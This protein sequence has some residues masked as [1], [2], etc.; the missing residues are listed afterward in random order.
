MVLFPKGVNLEDVESS[1]S[2]YRHFKLPPPFLLGAFRNTY[3]PRNSVLFS[4][5]VKIL[6]LW[7]L[8]ASFSWNQEARS[9]FSSTAA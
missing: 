4:G 7:C 5:L 8:E 2:R 9:A 6:E 3:I 1:M